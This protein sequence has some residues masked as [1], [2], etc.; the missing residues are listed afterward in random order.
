MHYDPRNFPNAEAP[1]DPLGIAAC[2]DGGKQIP[3]DWSY[4]LNDQTQSDSQ[5][6]TGKF[7]ARLVGRNDTIDKEPYLSQLTPFWRLQ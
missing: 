2:S 6:Q 5:P 7:T 4:H 1:V 3:L